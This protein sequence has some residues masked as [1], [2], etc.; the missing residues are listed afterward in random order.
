MD[1]FLLCPIVVGCDAIVISIFISFRIFM[2]CVSWLH[3]GDGPNGCN[4]TSYEA[5]RYCHVILVMRQLEINRNKKTRKKKRTFPSP[6]MYVCCTLCVFI[7]NKCTRLLFRMK[8]CKLAHFKVKI[9]GS[10][11]SWIEMNLKCWTHVL[12]MTLQFIHSASFNGQPFH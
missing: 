5:I 10:I 8:M 3:Q 11:E 9:N 4:R 6:F 7:K 2:S 1:S 12:T